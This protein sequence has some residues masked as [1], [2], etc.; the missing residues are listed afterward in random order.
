MKRQF[1]DRS[2]RHHRG[3]AL[4]EFLVLAAALL[5]LYLLMPMIA[6]YQDI[7]AQAEMAS[8]YVTF[9][10]VTRNDAQNSWKTPKELSTEIGRR[11]FSN[12]DSSIKTGDVAGNFS[13]NH[14]LF[15]RGP[16]NAPLI[17]DF[18]RDVAV[19]FG[20][21][22][23]PNHADAFTAASDGAPF[24]GVAGSAIGIHTANELGLGSR[25]I[26]TGN[27]SVQ[28]ANLPAGLKMLEP[29]DKINLAITR[30]T[31]VVI[32]GWQ[33]GR[34]AQVQ[35]RLD[36]GLL[37]PATY[38]KDAAAVVSGS[39]ALAEAGHISAPRLGQLDFWADVVPVDR[40]K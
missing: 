23:K 32:D 31:S 21:E 25:G 18:N 1:P 10:A 14:N 15:W 38:L 39:V 17:A 34:P 35:S 3:Q 26:Y 5:P 6:K 2:R 8:R 40:L 36:S 16:G 13:A 7:A 29:F 9:E 11:F 22:Q 28:L 37:V 20:P 24:N 4:T 19:S 33:A 27:V 30:H 12:T